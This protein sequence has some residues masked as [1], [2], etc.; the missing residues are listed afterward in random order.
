[1][2]SANVY[3][4]RGRSSEPVRLGSVRVA[5][6]GSA[7]WSSSLH[8]IMV[9]LTTGPSAM[10]PMLGEKLVRDLPTRLKN[11]PYLWAEPA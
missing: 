10:D 11:P 5:A 8:G 1:V 3:T 7:E 2:R 9:E 4:Q 6:D